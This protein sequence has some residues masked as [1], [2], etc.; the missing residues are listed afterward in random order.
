MAAS[1]P[2]F[3]FLTQYGPILRWFGEK[4]G[5]MPAV[6]IWSKQSRSAGRVHVTLRTDVADSRPG[7]LRTV[8]GMR[9]GNGSVPRIHVENLPL[10]LGCLPPTIGKS[11]CQEWFRVKPPVSKYV[12]ECPE[13]DCGTVP[14]YADQNH[15]VRGRVLVR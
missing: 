11:G 13:C 6:A 5:W 3:R 15:S 12:P 1:V 14:G 2:F 10:D 4:N 7:V 9:F 8:A